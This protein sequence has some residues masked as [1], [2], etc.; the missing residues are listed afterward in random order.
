MKCWVAFEAVQ[1]ER[2]AGGQDRQELVFLLAAGRPDPAVAVELLHLALSLEDAGAGGD[3]DVGDHEDGGGH[4][5]GD[6]PSVDELVKP[7]LVV[8]QASP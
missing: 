2:V 3:R 8:A 7:E 4:L 1:I 5:A 6:E